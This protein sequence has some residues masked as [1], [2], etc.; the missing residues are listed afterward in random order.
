MRAGEF[1]HLSRS[2][3]LFIIVSTAGH[4]YV[5]VRLLVE[6][7]WGSDLAL[8]MDSVTEG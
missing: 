8:I 1:V 6:L 7:K 4:E 5:Y 3:S 2:R